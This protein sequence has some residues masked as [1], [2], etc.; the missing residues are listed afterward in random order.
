MCFGKTV[1]LKMWYGHECL[2]WHPIQR[3]IR[4]CRTYCLSMDFHQSIWGEILGITESFLINL[5]HLLLSCNNWWLQRLLAVY[6]TLLNS[7]NLFT[8]KPTNSKVHGSSQVE[9]YVQLTKCLMS[10]LEFR[11]VRYTVLHWNGW[12]LTRK[13]RLVKLSKL[14]FGWKPSLIHS[15]CYKIRLKS[16]KEFWL[17]VFAYLL[18]RRVILLQSHN[19]CFPLSENGML[20]SML[21]TL[22]WSLA[23][24]LFRN[25]HMTLSRSVLVLSVVVR[26]CIQGRWRIWI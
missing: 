6:T 9:C 17:L 19:A 10:T 5:T 12:R 3:G 13:Q 25:A 4:C 2:L 15:V 7:V 21:A 20:L 11:T 16:R 23:L 24:G 14:E 8:R 1:R 26:L 18:N 22:Y